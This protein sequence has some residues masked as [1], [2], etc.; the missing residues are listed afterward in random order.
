MSKRTY[1][2]THFV[3]CSQIESMASACIGNYML[4]EKKLSC[5]YFVIFVVIR[6]RFRIP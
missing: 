6:L 2:L 5:V 3:P 1:E 4:V